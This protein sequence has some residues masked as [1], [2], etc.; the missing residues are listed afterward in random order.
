MYI[1]SFLMKNGTV[2]KSTGSWY[3]VKTTCG[4]FYECR[5]KGRFRMKGIKSTNPISVGDVVDFELECSNN[6]Q[7]GV[8]TNIHKRK[9]F[10]VRKSVN[11]SKQTHIIA[12]NIDQVF[13]LITIDNPPT[14]TSFIDRFL[15]AAESYSIKV[16][17][18]FNKIDLWNDKNLT[19]Q[20]TLI[21]TYKNIGYKCLT[22]SAI[23]GD[24][25]EQVKN[26]MYEKTSMFSGHSGVGKSTLINAI[27]PHLNL[28]TNQISTQHQQGQH[29]TTFAEM[30]DLNFGARIIDTPGIKGFGVV[31]MEPSELADYFPEFLVLKSQCKFNNCRHLKEP[32]CAVKMALENNT[33]AASRYKSYIQMMEGDTSTYRL[34]N[35][36]DQ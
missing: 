6:T 25:L 19:I 13:L 32:Q 36:E 5:I 26:L 28:R 23:N 21:K 1:Q 31:D 35:Y 17:L 15:V 11:L 20:N 34:D 8:I 30:F 27:E 2:Y 22:I 7:T 18:I 14:F 29:T 3:T 9:N 12:S 10:I 24:N 4:S 33:I 16:V